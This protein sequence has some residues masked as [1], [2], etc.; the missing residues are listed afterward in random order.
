[1]KIGKSI[2]D[3]RKRNNLS[4]EQFAKIFHVTRQTVSNWENEKSYPDLETL[5]GI[6]DR[7]DISLDKLMRENQ[8]MVKTIDRER[9][10]F[11]IFVVVLVSILLC[12]GAWYCCLPERKEG[13]V[14]RVLLDY[15]YS[16]LYSNEEIC[17]AGNI[18]IEAFKT[19]GGYKNCELVVISF[20]EEHSKG[21]SAEEGKETIVFK[22]YFTVGWMPTIDFHVPGSSDVVSWVLERDS[23]NSEWQIR[24]SGEG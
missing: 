2:L 11:K 10:R 19:C 23:E 20:D 21:I 5:V 6:S 24:T 13:K 9:K 7:F 18:V 14:D 15:Q 12:L 17:A 22:T 16:E 1:M 8:Q 3:I 4:Q